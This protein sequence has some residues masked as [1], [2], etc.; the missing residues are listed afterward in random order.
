MTDSSGK[1]YDAFAKAF[2]CLYKSIVMTWRRNHNE[3]PEGQKAPGK[4]ASG[5][6]EWR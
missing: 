3:K 4:V 2:R 1:D 5:G 6:P